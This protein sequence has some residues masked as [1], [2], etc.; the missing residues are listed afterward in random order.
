VSVT[1]AVCITTQDVPEKENTLDNKQAMDAFLAGI[2]RRA[3]Q[4][5]R[6]AI[7]DPDEALD[8]VQDAMIKLV[9]S[10]SAKPEAEWQ[11]LFFRIL[12]NRIID[13]QRRGNVRR[14]VMAFFGPRHDD[15]DDFDPVALAPGLESDQPDYQVSTDEK[16]A[17]LEV[18]VH[19]LPERQQQA[20][21]LRTVQEFDVATTAEIMGCSEGS[22]KTH[23]SRAL[24]KLREQL[25]EY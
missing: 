19:S 1:T 23:L 21:L 13:H 17:E 20:F 22:V 9:R 16:M 15:Q 2:E 24:K 5:A 3:F 4:M 6:F 8:L 18:A 25:G 7:G 11:P 14:K 10:Y 12:K